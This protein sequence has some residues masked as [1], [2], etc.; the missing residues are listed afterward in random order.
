MTS[1]HK[2]SKSLATQCHGPLRTCRTS[3][4]RLRIGK[5]ATLAWS[6]GSVSGSVR[7]ATSWNCKF[8]SARTAVQF[9]EDSASE[10]LLRVAAYLLSTACPEE[11]VVFD[12][13]SR[14]THRRTTEFPAHPLP[15]PHSPCRQF[16]SGRNRRRPRPAVRT[17]A[18]PPTNKR[19]RVSFLAR[20]RA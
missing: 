16:G 13:W 6:N 1:I 17:S 7:T 9:T 2:P 3:R 5:N 19:T 8:R 18:P 20:R 11:E 10:N 12:G 4:S 15:P 14:D